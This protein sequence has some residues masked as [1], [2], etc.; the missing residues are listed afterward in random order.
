MGCTG[1]HVLGSRNYILYYNP[2]VP[3]LKFSIVRILEVG[4]KNQVKLGHGND[5]TKKH[6]FEHLPSHHNATSV[7]NPIYPNNFC[8]SALSPS[9]PANF[10]RSTAIFTPKQQRI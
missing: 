10:L 4:Q 8:T 6:Y 3:A 1:T 2:K 5:S 7:N 9:S